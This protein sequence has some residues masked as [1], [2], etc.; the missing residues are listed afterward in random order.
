[1]AKLKSGSHRF[2]SEHGKEI[3]KVFYDSQIKYASGEIQ[4]TTEPDGAHAIEIVDGIWRYR[5]LWYGGEPFAGTTTIFLCDEACF[6]FQYRGRIT[7][8]VKDKQIVLAALMDA[9]QHPVMDTPW[10]GPRRFRT[11]HNLQYRN[12]WSG[13]LRNLSGVETITDPQEN[14]TFYKASYNG[15]IVNKDD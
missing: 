12:Q 7:P 3:R 11:I 15:I 6:V 8:F 13:G 10:R 4:P 2:A 9:L 5:D 1:M 14:R